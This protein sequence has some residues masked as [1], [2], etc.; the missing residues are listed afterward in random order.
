MKKLFAIA[1]AVVLAVAGVAGVAVAAYPSDSVT[2]Y[3]GCLSTGG[4][5]GNLGSVAVGLTPAKPCGSNEMLVHLSGG[6]ITQVSAG[7]G[8]SGGGTNGYV[9]LGIQLGYQLPQSSC[10]SGQFVASNGSGG[11]SCQSQKTYS[12]TNF[13]L[14]NQSCSTGQFLTGIDPSGVKQCAAD[15][16]YS[17]GVGLDL[18]GNTF[19]LSSAYQLPQSCLSGQVATSNGNGT[20][21]CHSGTGSLNTYTVTGAYWTL[22]VD[23]SGDTKTSTAFCNYGDI[24]TG[25]G[26]YTNHVDQVYNGPDN[27][28]WR[29]TGSVGPLSGGSLQAYA[30]C[31]HVG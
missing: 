10:S 20:W 29:V 31:L 7:T 2:Q 26:E 16:T 27:N 30:V 28:G 3:A 11:W 8:L 23:F 25:G 14:S 18:S 17:S 4:A 22:P 19:S 24:V 13:A 21:S 6:T 1:A 5:S 9:T 12:G 15:Q